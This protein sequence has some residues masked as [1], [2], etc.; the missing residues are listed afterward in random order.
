MEK[1]TVAATPAQTN[2]E[3][4]NDLVKKYMWWSMG[5]GLIPVPFEIGRAHV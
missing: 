5:A 3:L 2:L 4:S 1:E